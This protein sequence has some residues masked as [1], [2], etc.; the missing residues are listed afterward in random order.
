MPAN[1]QQYG[2][3]PSYYAWQRLKKNRNAFLSLVFISICVIIAIGG[4]AF[5]PDAT[6]NANKQNLELELLPPLSKVSILKTV[7]KETPRQTGFFHFIISGA[8]EK[9][10]E[11]A[12]KSYTKTKDS[13]SIVPYGGGR[14]ETYSAFGSSIISRTYWLGT[15]RYGRDML[16]R[17]LL[18]TRTS[19]AVGLISVIIS[20][21]IGLTLGAMAGFFR[22]WADH[23]ILWLMNVVWA[24]PTFLLVMAVSL[25][26][27]KGFWQVFVA[28]GLTMWVE[29]A[30]L[31][32]GQILSARELDYVTAAKALGFGSGRI[33]SRHILPNIFGPVLVIAAANFASAIL[34][35]AG[36]SFLGLGVQP[37]APSW[38]VM[39]NDHYGYIVLNAAYL[40]ILP[41]VAIMLLVLAFNLLGNGLRDALDVKMR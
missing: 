6:P 5:L 15:D 28:V 7:K 27:G 9:Y 12:L 13:I 36:L 2:K 22:G 4:Y 39:I 34:L 11:K 41:G 17:L 16:S 1:P 10:D 31:V 40:A 25:V 24:V 19:F 26:L 35:E 32:R 23:L 20:L 14:G 18:G 29:V 38:G 21:V 30:R 33:I 37:P 8:K 3:S